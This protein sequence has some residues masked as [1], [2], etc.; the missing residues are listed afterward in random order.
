MVAVRQEVQASGGAVEQCLTVAELC[1]AIEGG[2]LPAEQ[3][4][5][6]YSVK[7]RDLNRLMLGRVLGKVVPIRG[8]RRR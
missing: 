1:A 7:W 4:G 8:S 5:D 3:N 6:T 2:R